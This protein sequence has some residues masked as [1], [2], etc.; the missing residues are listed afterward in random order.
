M[1]I[2]AA[3]T[4]FAVFLKKKKQQELTRGFAELNEV[5]QFQHQG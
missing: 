5:R 1:A 3:G 2:P 4:R